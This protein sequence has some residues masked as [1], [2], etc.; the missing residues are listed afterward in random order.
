[1]AGHVS[2][3]TCM[4]ERE[5]LQPPGQKALFFHSTKSKQ[6]TEEHDGSSPGA[7]RSTPPAQT[8]RRSGASQCPRN[9]GWNLIA[10]GNF[11]TRYRSWKSSRMSVREKALRCNGKSC[12][13]LKDQRVPCCSDEALVK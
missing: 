4:C 5:P 12:R 11:Y 9:T 3:A 10:P 8:Q 13:W 2:M 1:M 6:C 7:L